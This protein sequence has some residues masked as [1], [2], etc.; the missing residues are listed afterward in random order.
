MGPSVAFDPAV[1]PAPIGQRD[2]TAAD[3]HWDN[4][5]AK[6]AVGWGSIRIAIEHELYRFPLRF[7][8]YE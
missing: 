7:G 1:H 3:V 2:C 5:L 6:V 4:A 8:E